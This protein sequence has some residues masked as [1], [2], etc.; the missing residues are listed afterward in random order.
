MLSRLKTR[1]WW[2]VWVGI[3][4]TIGCLVFI[5]ANTGCSSTEAAVLSDA[6]RACAHVSKGKARGGDAE[7]CSKAVRRAYVQSVGATRHTMCWVDMRGVSCVPRYHVNRWQ[8]HAVIL[9]NGRRWRIAGV[10]YPSTGRFVKA[11][12]SGAIT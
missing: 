7:A 8:V 2:E 6:Q 5:L 10:A 12:L 4:V 11:V 1:G 9:D 3:G